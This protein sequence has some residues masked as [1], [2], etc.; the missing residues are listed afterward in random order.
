MSVRKDEKK[1]KTR[2]VG[3][4]KSHSVPVESSDDDQRKQ[5]NRKRK[6][7]KNT[8]S[9]IPISDS[10]AFSKDEKKELRKRKKEEKQA[11]LSKV[12]T[13]DQDGIAY[14]KIQIKRMMKRVKRGLDPVPTEEEEREI[15]RARKA[16]EKE[17]ELEMADMLFRKEDVNGDREDDIEDQSGDENESV[18]VDI[19]DDEEEDKSKKDVSAARHLIKKKARSKPVPNDYVCSACKNAHSPAHWIYDCPDKLYQPG[20]NQKKK[21]LR[22]IHESSAKKVFVSGL[23]FDATIKSVTDY[24]EN[25]LKCGKVENCKLLTFEDTKR[26]KGQGFITFETELAA[27]NALKKNGTVMN[28][29]SQKGQNSKGIRTK[30]LRLGVKNVVNRALTKCSIKK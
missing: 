15:L 12:P 18:D 5:G 24:F 22:G 13:V 14:T 10:K 27:A 21:S 9:E 8:V 20:T 6:R 28:M 29:S 16:E 3:D 1:A 11:L 2:T 26:C 23:P 7:E 19:T 30:E 4:D 17:T 25:D